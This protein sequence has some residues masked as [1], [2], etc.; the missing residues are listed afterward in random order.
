VNIFA[1]GGSGTDGPG[2]LL[3]VQVGFWD[4]VLM[5]TIGDTSTDTDIKV[6]RKDVFAGGANR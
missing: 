4:M 6:T 2:Y 3:D 5:I 1:E